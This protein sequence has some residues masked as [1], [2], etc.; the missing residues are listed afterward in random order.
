MIVVSHLFVWGFF[1]TYMYWRP[2][3]AERLN[4]SFSIECVGCVTSLGAASTLGWDS[5]SCEHTSLML[6]P[7]LGRLVFTA[8]WLQLIC[9]NSKST[10][11][12]HLHGHMDCV[13]PD[14]GSPITCHA[15]LKSNCDGN[16]CFG[17]SVVS[18][19]RLLLGWSGETM[20]YF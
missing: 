2:I 13:C 18:A 17:L 3:P 6:A 14:L 5:G 20:P 15:G 19:A 12:T 1:F 7:P 4:V 16:I 9:L 8:T 10:E 11:H